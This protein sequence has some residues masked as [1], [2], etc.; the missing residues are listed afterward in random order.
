MGEPQTPHFYD[1][2]T[3][4]HVQGSQNQRFLSLETP[5]YLERDKKIPGTCLKHIIFANLKGVKN[6]NVD[7]V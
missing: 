4:G 7:N 5:G 1:F 3:F 2:G 6:Q